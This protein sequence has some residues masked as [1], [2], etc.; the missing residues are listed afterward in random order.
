[1]SNVGK[2]GTRHTLLCLRNFPANAV[3]KQVIPLWSDPHQGL[4]P[5]R[6]AGD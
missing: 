4:T 2:V 6:G 3:K 1:M 5:L